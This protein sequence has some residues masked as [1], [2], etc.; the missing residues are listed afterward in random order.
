MLCD[1][2]AVINTAL[3]LSSGCGTSS[4]S[5]VHRPDVIST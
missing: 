3:A 5:S 1:A 4:M 2:G